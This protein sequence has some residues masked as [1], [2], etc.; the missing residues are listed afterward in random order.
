MGLR[1]TK[2]AADE[3]ERIANYLIKH[4]PERAAD[5]VRSI[6]NA[7]SALLTFPHRGRPGRKKATRELVI[8][9]LQYVIVYRIS[10]DIVHVT[11]ILRTAQK[12]P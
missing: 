4:A 6:Y 3:L 1:W 10:G 7:P 12:W 11:R 8:P 9:S 5:L 2:E